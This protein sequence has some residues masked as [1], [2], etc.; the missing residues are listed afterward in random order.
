MTVPT[1]FP[2]NLSWDALP[3]LFPELP[4]AA[5]WLPLLQQHAEIV[6]KNAERVRVTSVAGDDAVRRQYAESLEIASLV[7]ILD[8]SEGPV[9]DVGSGG[10]FPGMILAA[11]FEQR[12]VHLIEPLKKRA[13]LLETMASQ[14]ELSNVTVHPDRAEDAGRGP[15]R[16]RASVVTARAV[17][18]LRELLEYTAPLAAIGGHIVLPKGSRLDAE[19]VDAA[20]AMDELSCHVEARAPMRQEVSAAGTIL[21]LTKDGPTPPRYPRRAGM[22]GKRPI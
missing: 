10:G 1:A 4:N 8:D 2:S 17:A 13:A 6:E 12:P 16:E 22:P 5:R 21:V 11:T 14:L 9:V 18:E 3:A 19:L 7:C 20:R 15:L